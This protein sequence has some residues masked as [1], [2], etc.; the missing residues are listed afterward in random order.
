MQ[1]NLRR[2][3]LRERT[4]AAHKVVDSV[5]GDFTTAGDYRRYVAASYAFRA[6]LERQLSARDWPNALESWRPGPVTAALRDDL[7]DLDVPL[8]AEAAEPVPAEGL[9]GTLYVLEGSALGATILLRRAEALGFG[10][11]FGARHLAVQCHDIGRWRGFLAA[12]EAAQPFDIDRAAEAS[13]AAFA[14][15]AS[16]YRGTCP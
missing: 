11:Q 7:D 10:A 12:L 2:W 1:K 15:A 14:A 3:Q 4:A 9:L 6:P 16:A 8:P 13:L 5:V